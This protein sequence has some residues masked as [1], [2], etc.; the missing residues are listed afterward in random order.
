MAR[1]PRNQ[2]LDQLF[3]HF[4]DT[5]HWGLRPLRDKTQQPEV[6]LKEVL[7]EIAFLHRSGEHNGM[8]ELKDNF[9]DENVRDLR[10]YNSFWSA[11]ISDF[12][13]RLRMFQPAIQESRWALRWNLKKIMMK[14]KMT[15]TWKRSHDFDFVS[16]FSLT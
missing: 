3:S 6:Y 14:M 12:R 9:K 8:W 11:Y 13:S 15:T 7:S 1:I 2:L 4:R 10:F 16:C 5:P